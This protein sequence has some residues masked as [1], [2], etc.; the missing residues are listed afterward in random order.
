MAITVTRESI[1]IGDDDQKTKTFD[2]QPEEMLS[3]FLRLKVAE[4]LPYTSGLTVWAIYMG[5]NEDQPTAERESAEKKVAFIH[6]I[7][8]RCSKVEIR[9]GDR[10]V[11]SFDTDEM[12]CAV[13]R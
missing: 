8:N 5:S 13:Y 2:Y 3:S 6:K 7:E 9:G 11:S 4:Y 12:Y 10:L 1:F